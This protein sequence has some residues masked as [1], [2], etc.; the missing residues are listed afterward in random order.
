[1]STAFESEPRGGGVGDSTHAT[2]AAAAA[3][4]S[5]PAAAAGADAERQQG[6]ERLRWA[7]A[8][9]PCSRTCCFLRGWRGAALA[10]G[11]SALVVTVIVI[12][13]VVG[14]HAGGGGGAGGVCVGLGAVVVL[15]AAP[16]LGGETPGPFRMVGGIVFHTM[17]ILR[18]YN[19]LESARGP[20]SWQADFYAIQR[21]PGVVLDREVWLTAFQILQMG[22]DAFSTSMPWTRD[23]WIPQLYRLPSLDA[24][25]LVPSL[26]GVDA[27]WWPQFVGTVVVLFA[28]DRAWH[29]GTFKGKPHVVDRSLVLASMFMI[30]ASR[31]VG[32]VYLG[33]D[34]WA[35]NGTFV[36]DR[37]LSCWLSP[38]WYIYAVASS[39]LLTLLAFTC[40]ATSNRVARLRYSPEYPCTYDFALLYCT[41]KVV[42]TWLFVALGQHHA[43]VAHVLT[44]ACHCSLIAYVAVH[45]PCVHDF[46]NRFNIFG[47]CHT[48][49]TYIAALNALRIGDETS[50]SSVQTFSWLSLITLSTYVL[51]EARLHAKHK[52]AAQPFQ[53]V[54]A[55]GDADLEYQLADPL[56]PSEMVRAWP[57]MRGVYASTPMTSGQRRQYLADGNPLPPPKQFRAKGLGIDTDGVCCHASGKPC[58]R[59]VEGVTSEEE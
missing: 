7:A 58:A 43:T 19:T 2:A 52:R 35:G 8:T 41:V 46:F 25:A 21:I 57:P 31:V 15:V 12:S 5:A 1:M 32:R 36:A 40:V 39:W 47:C 9:C 22:G 29:H 30:P 42:T 6:R 24:T 49:I 18:A 59:V 28:L 51:L 27:L 37:T 17:S 55:V 34:Y 14:A 44:I 48:I 45:K 10:V 16:G 33:C 50:N 3:A 20:D 53:R 13:A 23:S 26:F 56:D 4:S 54:Y 38:G 11:T